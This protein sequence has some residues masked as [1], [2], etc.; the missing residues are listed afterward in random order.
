MGREAV[1]HLTE[2]ERPKGAPLNTGEYAKS[3]DCWELF[4]KVP[5]SLGEDF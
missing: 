4:K 2:A 5:V 1:I 3:L